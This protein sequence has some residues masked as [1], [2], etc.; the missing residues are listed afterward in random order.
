[1]ENRNQ[2]IKDF[3]NYI[4]KFLNLNGKDWKEVLKENV[5]KPDSNNCEWFAELYLLQN[6]YGYDFD[7][8]GTYLEEK[9]MTNTGLGQFFTPMHIAKLMSCLNFPS[10]IQDILDSKYI[11][12]SDPCCGSY[13]IIV[14]VAKVIRNSRVLVLLQRIKTQKLQSWY[15]A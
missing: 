6:K 11:T 3:N 12:V 7:M 15:I 13:V 9:K 14:S 10:D 4:D 5:L 8:F 2:F 1:M